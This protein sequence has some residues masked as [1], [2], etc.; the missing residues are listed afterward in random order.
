[1]SQ[2]EPQ[3]AF[4]SDPGQSRSDNQDHVRVEHLP[5][6]TLLVVADGMGGHQG[7]ALA[8][9][10]AV[11]TIV[12]FM[13]QFVPEGMSPE[14]YKAGLNAAI[15]DANRTI[16]ATAADT[17]EAF[18]MGTTVVIALVVGDTVYVAHV[19]DSRLYH[20]RG[21]VAHRVTHDHTMVQALIDHGAITPEQA[22]DHPDAHRLSQALG[23]RSEVDPEIRDEALVLSPGDCLVLCSDGLFD[24]VSDEEIAAST[25]AGDAEAAARRLVDLANAGGGPD[26]VSV[27]VY[28]VPGPVTQRVATRVRDTV[29]RGRQRWPLVVLAVLVAVATGAV[30]L[31]LMSGESSREA[32]VTQETEPASST[33]DQVGVSL[34]D[35]G[36]LGTLDIAEEVES[37]M[38]GSA[39]TLSD[40]GEL[41]PR[42]IVPR[43]VP[44]RGAGGDV[45]GVEEG[46]EDP[47]QDD[48]AESDHA[49]QPSA[50]GGEIREGAGVQ[51]EPS[52][53]STG[54]AALTCA[55]AAEQ[56]YQSTEKWPK[57]WRRLR[58]MKKLYGRS[59]LED[60]AYL[61]ALRKVKDELV[62]DVKQNPDKCS[63][64]RRT[65]RHLEG[66]YPAVLDWKQI[67]NSLTERCSGRM[68][69]CN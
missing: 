47:G 40:P 19:G 64:W 56:I 1:M 15:L 57:N 43:G 32:P 13:T 4:L 69:K 39:P 67:C 63:Y 8:S 6:G 68:E 58:D 11:D 66:T 31:A 3:V 7:G 48:G 44:D 33:P 14:S 21:D 53:M 38:S 62:A 26:N 25:R 28:R 23:Y 30:V 35:E 41:G 54:A 29:R 59:C 37:P 55:E 50:E 9:R 24:V 51:M 16:H 42:G 65:F 52:A 2:K 49:G 36:H 61:Q 10:L 22:K 34:E 27:V 17:P 46:F 60:K 45:T 12:G 18:N 20:I 5:F